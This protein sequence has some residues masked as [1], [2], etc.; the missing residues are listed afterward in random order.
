MG[1]SDKRRTGTDVPVSSLTPTS[2]QEGATHPVRTTHPG[3]TLRTPHDPRT[4]VP[5]PPPPRRQSSG[6]TGPARHPRRGGPCP[7]GN[8]R[9]PAS[10]PPPLT[11]RPS[12]PSA[13]Y[14]LRQLPALARGRAEPAR[15]GTGGLGRRSLH[16]RH[17]RGNRR[18]IT[19]LPGARSGPRD[20]PRVG[21]QRRAGGADLHEGPD[22]PDGGVVA[23]DQDDGPRAGGAR[24]FVGRALQLAAAA[25]GI[26]PDGRRAR[27]RG[28][29]RF[30][31]AAQGR[32]IA[33][34]CRH[35]AVGGAGDGGG[36]VAAPRH[37][38]RPRPSRATS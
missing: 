26:G 5:P 29:V 12:P 33:G 14:G 2:D 37:A 20:D 6:R 15:H 22:L 8:P 10:V 1:P 28:G 4:P 18:R 9:A 3:H 31:E 7:H 27:V 13:R 16:R 34:T 35:R 24:A 32:D 17:R 23:Q 25:R 19:P 36:P 21:H 30:R 38:D 11:P